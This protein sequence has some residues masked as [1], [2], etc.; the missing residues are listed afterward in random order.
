MAANKDWPFHQFDVKNVFLR[1]DLKGEVFIDIPPSFEGQ[2]RSVGVVTKVSEEVEGSKSN[3]EHLD[4]KFP[5]ILSGPSKGSNEP[6][7]DPT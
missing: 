7:V 3:C 5:E 1:G 2:H 6:C 4:H